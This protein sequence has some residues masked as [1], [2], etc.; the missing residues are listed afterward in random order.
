MR[1][2]V[3][4]RKPDWLKRQIPSGTEFFRLKKNLAERELPTICQSARCPNIAECWNDRHATFLIMGDICT[5]HCSFCS[6]AKGIPRPLDDDED[7]KIAQLADILDSRHV[8]IT[9]VSRDD[10]A[11]SG[12]SHFAKI[13][14]SLKRRRPGMT[15]EVLIPDFSGDGGRL[16][17]VLDARPDVLGH[18][19]ETVAA[20]YPH[21]NRRS[22]AYRH[23]LSIL[24]AGKQKSF[25]TK[26]GFMVGLGETM[27]E[28]DGLL[29]DLRSCGTDLLTIGQY[30]QPGR[31]Q[32][33]VQKYYS[34]AEFLILKQRALALGFSGV[35][36]GPLVRSS[37]HCQELYKA[38]A[39]AL[40]DIQ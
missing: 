9:S 37:Y 18:N 24:H 11:D 21:L 15:V 5:R 1:E 12:S 6:V 13:I 40:P 3:Q 20:L 39:N 32:T 26:S 17:T 35:E 14:R 30:L 33:A 2:N 28:I 4:Q 8:V 16:Q 29:R 19:L 27:A 34:P 10:L 22:E 36:A 31:G 23:S 7:Q 38:V 25:I